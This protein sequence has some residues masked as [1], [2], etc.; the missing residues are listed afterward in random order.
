MTDHPV[1]KV[2]FVGFGGEERIRG[3]LLYRI[4]ARHFEVVLSEV[5]DY[6]FFNSGGEHFRYNDCVKIVVQSENMTVDFNAYDYGMGFDHMVFGDR[7][8]RHPLFARYPA[9][10]GL[11]DA[12]KKAQVR[13]EEF[14]DRKFCSFV[15][16]HQAA[17][18]PIREKFFR[19]LS[20]YK[21]VDSGGR[22][23]NNVGGPVANKLA[24]CKGYKFNIAFENSSSPGYTTEKILDAYASFSVPVYYGNPTVE[25]DFS[26]ASM[27]RVR[28]EADIDQAVEEIVKLDNNDDAYLEKLLTPCIA[29]PDYV[30]YGRRLESFLL[31]IFEQPVKDAKRRNRYGCQAVVERRHAAIFKSYHAIVNSWP[32]A[33]ARNIAKNVHRT[34]GKE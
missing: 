12:R 13:M 32:Y 29:G 1:R 18:D 19:R 4:L 11:E 24:F 5:P 31:H 8:L 6:V 30:E 33:V 27:V 23:L 28:S 22:F 26:P 20:E 10:A 17:G 14:L 34:F 16:S 3:S 15:V 25:T 21:R 7:Y 2:Q 9:F